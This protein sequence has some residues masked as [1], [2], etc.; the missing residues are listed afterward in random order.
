MRVVGIL[1]MVLGFLAGLVAAATGVAAA[2]ER[3]DEYFVLALCLSISSVGLF[4]GGAVLT[5]GGRPQ[6]LM[7]QSPAPPA[8]T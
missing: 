5:A 3:E 1:I 8:Q 6:Y 2:L 4:I 7:I